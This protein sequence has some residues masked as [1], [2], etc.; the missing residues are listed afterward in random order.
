MVRTRADRPAR[1]EFF[2]LALAGVGL[3]VSL[4]GISLA[5][6]APTYDAHL[7]AELRW[8]N[9]GPFR[10]GRTK[11]VDGIPSQPNVF[12]IGAVNGGVW[13]TTDYGR[14]WNPIFDD[15][16]TGSIG[17]IAVA[18]SNPEHH[19]RRQRRRHAAPGPL[20]RRRHLQVDRRRQDVDAPRPARRPADSADHRRSAQSRTACS[21]PCSVIRTGPNAERGIFRSHRRRPDVR[22]RCST[23]R[24]HRRRRP[25]VRSGRRRTSIYAALWEARQGPWENG[26][27]TGPGSGLLQ[28][29]RRR[30]DVEAADAGAADVCR[31][32]R[33]H[34]HHRGAERAQP[35]VR[36]RGC[37]RARRHLSLGRRRRDVDARERGPAR[38]S[39]GRPMRP[40]CAC[41]PRTRTSSTCRRS[42]R[43]NRPTAAGRSP[44]CAARRAATTIRRSG[45]TRAPGHHDHDGRSGRDRH[46]ERRRDVELLVQPADRAVLPREHRQRVSVSRVRRPAGKR[47]GVRREPRRRRADHV[48]RLASGGRRGVRLRRA[49][50]ARSRHRLRRQGHAVRSAD[51]PGAE[52]R[53]AARRRTIATL[54]TAPLLF[55]PVDPR[56]LFFAS[57]T[58][59]KTTNGGRTG[60]RSVRPHARDVGRAA[61]TSACTASAPT[62]RPRAAA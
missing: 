5:Q 54:R 4:F 7:F 53:A 29:D 46:G 3:A 18:P 61:R 23:R 43:G 2:P 14:T 48:P 33:P 13:K 55:S 59:W 38:R 35:A 34:R 56:T 1:R 62:A 11:A 9:I 26:A 39:R 57:N 16:P 50:S 36:R 12:Y 41:I 40:T 58:L 6:S 27:W 20:D 47:I 28:I 17:A 22:A 60:R 51:R 42:S 8:R 10:G 30:H 37:G 15:Q 31:G 25:R 24:E 49:R 32:P 19:L 52:R 45:S 21:S 44:R